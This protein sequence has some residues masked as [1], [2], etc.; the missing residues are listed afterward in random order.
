MKSTYNTILKDMQIETRRMGKIKT[1]DCTSYL[2]G[3][4]AART[5]QNSSYLAVV[6]MTWQS[7]MGKSLE[8]SFKHIFAL[9]PSNPSPVYPRGKKVDCYK[10]ICVHIS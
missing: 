9:S 8:V 5:L 3:V 10:K 1:A 7:H 2:K 6:G 4:G